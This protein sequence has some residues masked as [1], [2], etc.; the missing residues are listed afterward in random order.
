MMAALLLG[1][2]SGDLPAQ[3]A[4]VALTLCYI[5]IGFAIVSALLSLF[6]E[7]PEPATKS[8]DEPSHAIQRDF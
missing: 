5:G 1:W 7:E 3:A 4:S 2:I 6:E 8:L